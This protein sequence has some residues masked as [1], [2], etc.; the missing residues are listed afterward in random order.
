MIMADMH[1]LGEMDVNDRGGEHEFRYQESE[2]IS[3]TFGR[4][5][6]Q[7]V[8]PFFAYGLTP[9]PY[10][11]AQKDIHSSTV[12]PAND[13]GVSITIEGQVF[14]GEGM[15]V[16]DAMV[17]LLQADSSGN[18]VSEGRN[19]GFTGYARCGTGPDGPASSGGDTHFRFRTIKPGPA[20]AGMAPFITV[21]VTMRGLLN[22][23]ITRLY[24]PTDDHAKDPVMQQVP[25]NRRST[26]IAV[27]TSPNRYRFDIHMQGDN[28]TVF[29]DI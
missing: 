19:D 5:P 2:R 21:I 22:H 12:Q 15:P 8:G 29:F 28:E 1:N 20:L 7:T 18:Y 11:Y 17:E 9:G 16:H 23:C 27:E 14:D 10:G 26:L 24:F 3:P 13:T 4:T 6:S 25:E